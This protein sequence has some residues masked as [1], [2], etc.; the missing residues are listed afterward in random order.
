VQTVIRYV[1]V[2]SVTAPLKYFQISIAS[3]IYWFVA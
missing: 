3:V 2:N 1:Y